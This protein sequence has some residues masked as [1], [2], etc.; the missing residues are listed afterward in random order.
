[1]PKRKTRDDDKSGSEYY[2]SDREKD[3]DD[4]Y[5]APATQ[6][7]RMVFVIN[8]SDPDEIVITGLPVSEAPRNQKSILKKTSKESEKMLEYRL[9]TVDDEFG[10][11]AKEFEDEEKQEDENNR[12]KEWIG[13]IMTDGVPWSDVPIKDSY[14]PVMIYPEIDF[15]Y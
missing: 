15:E 1:M 13:K 5:K 7:T 4:E 9:N 3:S 11:L 14:N 8:Q 6:R 2:P 12:V 10:G